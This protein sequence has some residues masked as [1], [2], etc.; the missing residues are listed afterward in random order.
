MNPETKYEYKVIFLKSKSLFLKTGNSFE[1]A[2][3]ELNEL[4][5]QGWRLINVIS[6]SIGGGELGMYAFFERTIK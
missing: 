2:E 1:E 5:N 3:K 4:A 6:S